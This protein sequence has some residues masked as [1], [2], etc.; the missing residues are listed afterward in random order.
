MWWGQEIIQGQ[1]WERDGGRQSLT[2]KERMK[3]RERKH[4]IQERDNQIII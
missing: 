4:T 1:K 3:E 2:V